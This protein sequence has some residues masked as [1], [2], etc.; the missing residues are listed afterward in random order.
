M[1]GNGVKKTESNL[2]FFPHHFPPRLGLGFFSQSTKMTIALD[3]HP[4]TFQDQ[5]SGYP[6]KGA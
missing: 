1:G 5:G 3:Y 4:S 6:L 2:V